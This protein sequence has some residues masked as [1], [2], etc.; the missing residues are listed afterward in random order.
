MTTSSPIRIGVV[1]AG[2][3]TRDR[4]I[5]GFKAIDGVEIVAVANRSRESGE[6][7]AR[8]FDIPRVFDTWQQ[9]I[10]DDSIDESPV[11]RR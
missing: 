10:E 8:Q 11:C 5:P 6:R 2:A 3:N 1:G 7:V 9:L 4:H